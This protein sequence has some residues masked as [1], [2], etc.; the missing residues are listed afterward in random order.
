MTLTDFNMVLDPKVKGTLNLHHAL[1]DE[2][3]LN[4]FV[5][6]GSGCGI[7]GNPGQSNYSAASTFL[8][9]FARYRRSLGLPACTIDLGS[10]ENIGYVSENP[11]IAATLSAVGIH[12]LTERD[13]LDIM[14][15]AILAEPVGE[16]IRCFDP[17]A[18]GQII[19]AF[20]A[21]IRQNSRWAGDSKFTRLFSR[22]EN[23]SSGGG[24]SAGS[25]TGTTASADDNRDAELHAA[26]TTMTSDL[27]TINSPALHD[28][29][30]KALARK[31]ASVLSIS[32]DEISLSQSPARY[33]I[34]SLIAIE[35]RSW[36]RT[37]L[38]VDLQVMELLNVDSVG[39]VVEK[40]V[41]RVKVARQAAKCGQ[42]MIS[43]RK[44]D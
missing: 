11:K 35:L 33:G 40:V 16:D 25:G 44:G 4:F 30:S 13:F 22:E 26:L 6:L 14:E 41:E 39:E 43:T 12:L 15:A 24:K 20:G 3:D 17:Y 31:L 21:N 1:Q 28:L 29:V 36:A 27:A 34:D 19:R 7:V 23:N 42:D 38:G 18:D 10:V 32:P 37:V 8:D 9:S 5:I 2:E